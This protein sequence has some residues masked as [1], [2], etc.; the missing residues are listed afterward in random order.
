MYL[1][2]AYTLLTQEKIKNNSAS[3]F[4]NL[5]TASLNLNFTGSYTKRVYFLLQD[6]TAF[7]LSWSFML[8]C[9]MLPYLRKS[10]FI[11][12]L[13]TLKPFFFTFLVY[14][15]VYFHSILSGGFKE[16]CLSEKLLQYT[17]HFYEKSVYQK[18]GL[19]WPTS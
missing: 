4:G 6:K 19:K 9:A 18:M 16:P 7:N 14:F 2:M 1:Q 13:L 17:A 15:T 5:R 11:V 3:K 8:Y 12:V 10:G